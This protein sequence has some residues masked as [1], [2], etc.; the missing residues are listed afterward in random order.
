MVLF[1]KALFLVTDFRKIIMKFK[2]SIEFSSKIFSKFLINLLFVQKAKKERGG[3]INFLK[4]MLK[5][6][7]KFLKKS[8]E[9]F[10]KFSENFSKSFVFVQTPQKVTHGLYSLFEK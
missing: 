9:N 7:H 8:F 5:N 10:R 2:L 4:N 6:M 3:L 1:W